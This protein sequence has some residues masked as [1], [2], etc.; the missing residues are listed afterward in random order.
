MKVSTNHYLV[1][2]RTVREA[3]PF[4]LQILSWRTQGQRIFRPLH[5]RLGIFVILS[6]ALFS[7]ILFS[8]SIW[9]SVCFVTC[10]CVWVCICVGVCLCGCVYVCVCVCGFC[11]VW[12]CVCVG[13]VM[14]GCGCGCVHVWVL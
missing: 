10:G 5:H 9:S 2:R 4:H 8:F 13:F 6:L 14:C 3:V 7:S 12:V 11:N 1:Q